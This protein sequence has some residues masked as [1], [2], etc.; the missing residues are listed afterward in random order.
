ML[1]QSSPLFVCLKQ[2]FLLM[3]LCLF[4]LYQISLCYFSQYH[5][6]KL[7]LT[8]NDDDDGTTDD[9]GKVCLFETALLTNESVSVYTSSTWE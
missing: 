7:N 9:D 5:L 6:A 3:S 8:H 2:R 4:M 1:K